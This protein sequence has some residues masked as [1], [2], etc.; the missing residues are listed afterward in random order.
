[1]KCLELYFLHHYKHL[2]AK[3]ETRQ[4]F[5][6]NKNNMRFQT[7]MH[8]LA[9]QTKQIRP[10]TILKFFIF[11]Q[12]KYCWPTYFETVS[13]TKAITFQRSAITFFPHQALHNFLRVNINCETCNI[14]LCYFTSQMICK[15]GNSDPS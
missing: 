8:F 2:V 13:F 14:Y 1:M 9:N 12:L 3:Q 15:Q 4:Q 7:S 10:D 6:A 11:H 5:T